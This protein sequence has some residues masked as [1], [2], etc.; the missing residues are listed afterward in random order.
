MRP[1]NL[2][3]KCL[4][5]V[6]LALTSTAAAG[7]LEFE[8]GEAYPSLGQVP[9]DLV[10]A[11][12]DG[13]AILDAIAVGGANGTVAVWPGV[14]GGL[15]SQ[16]TNF[17]LGSIAYSLDAGDLNADGLDDLVVSSQS[18]PGVFVLRSSGTG[19]MQELLSTAAPTRSVALE[20]LDGDGDLDLVLAVEPT[21]FGLP[22]ELQTHLN[23]GLGNFTLEDAH[24]TIG[25][26]FDLVTGDL[27]G[28]GV[29]DVMA[30]SPGAVPV[31][32]GAIETFLGAGNGDL[33]PVDSDPGTSGYL[34][35]GDYDE[36][37]ILDVASTVLNDFVCAPNYATFRGLGGGMIEFT[38]G[39]EV[40]C[41]P[42]SLTAADFDLDGHLDL[43]LGEQF[44]LMGDGLYL[45]LGNGAGQFD[46]GLNLM[47]DGLHPVA[48]DVDLDGRVD[49][50]VVRVSTGELVVF[51]NATVGSPIPEFLRGDVNLDLAVEISDA[52]SVLGAL[53]VPGTPSPSCPDTA[54][55][56]DDGG[57]D[58][59]DAIAILSHLFSGAGALP[60]P[61]PD[62]GT[63]PTPDSLGP[64]VGSTCP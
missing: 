28:D 27:D 58:V 42:Y 44:G 24:A 39:H 51:R 46:P 12:V 47:I 7:S 49:L 10:V 4:P 13:D 34:A 31:F 22:G 43:A 6:L 26:V 41:Y 11:D 14:G 53:F 30:T 29:A 3:A 8:P 9:N 59:S 63:D 32:I 19:F 61:F 33:L 57:F 45:E 36:D 16:S 35:L 52:I 20:D 18:P 37:G 60:A 1:T 2:V 23:D 40:G 64:C 50:L 21:G 38:S 25:S 48:A 17:D 5:I 54:D 56:N 62:C 55:A 15:F